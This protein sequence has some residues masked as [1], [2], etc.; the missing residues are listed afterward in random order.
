VFVVLACAA[1][2]VVVASLVGRLTFLPAAPRTMREDAGVEPDRQTSSLAML[3]RSRASADPIHRSPYGQQERTH[4]ACCVVATRPPGDEP[5][6]PRASRVPRRTPL[7]ALT[8]F[9]STRRVF[10]SRVVWIVP[11]VQAQPAVACRSCGGLQKVQDTA[12]REASGILSLSRR[13]ARGCPNSL[14]RREL[15]ECLNV[16]PGGGFRKLQVCPI[17]PRRRRSDSRSMRVRTP[18][19]ASARSSLFCLLFSQGMVPDGCVWSRAN[20]RRRAAT[21]WAGAALGALGGS[22]AAQR[23]AELRET[24]GRSLAVRI[25]TLLGAGPNG[26][27][28]LAANESRRPARGE[29]ARFRAIRYGIDEVRTNA[30]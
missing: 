4:N 29:N 26:L 14:R 25:S 20:P 9:Q 13:K 19:E 12:R 21:G 1:Q 10:L 7:V 18:P 22:N 15:Q 3:N 5:S 24:K 2:Y 28:G 11:L 23:Q 8:W 6:H 27:I 30:A 17:R 16:R